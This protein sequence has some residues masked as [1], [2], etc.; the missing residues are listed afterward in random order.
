MTGLDLDV[1]VVREYSRTDVTIS[2]DEDLDELVRH[3]LLAE[4]ST[5]SWEVALVCVSDERL[6]RMHAD[7][8]G[9]DEPTDVMTFEHEPEDGEPG[10]PVRG[11][12]IVISVDRAAEQSE[13]GG[14][15]AAR[16]VLFLVTHGVLHLTGWT[17][18]SP[19]DRAAMLD[20]G[21]AL[22]SA[23]ERDRQTGADLD[24][25]SR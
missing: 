16:E 13:A 25:V 20:R 14:N 17:D 18:A 15:D 2:P 5:G 9:I 23:W 1:T 10:R 3:V 7:F 21:E 6:Q 24:R 12:D 4:G 22:L 19:A 11:G 8:M